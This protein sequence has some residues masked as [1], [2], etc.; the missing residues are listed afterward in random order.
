MYLQVQVI[1]LITGDQQEQNLQVQFVDD[2]SSIKREEP[3]ENDKEY[4]KFLETD[5]NF[6]INK[7]FDDKEDFNVKVIYLTFRFFLGS[8]KREIS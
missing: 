8:L 7:A 3:D 1:G 5:K 4:P 2:K 6:P